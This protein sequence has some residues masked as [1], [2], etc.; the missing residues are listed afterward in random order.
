MKSVLQ[1]RLESRRQGTKDAR[2]V[3]AGEP[4]AADSGEWVGLLGINAGD[5][6][7]LLT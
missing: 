5:D 7:E 6:N 4:V 2:R 3:N 1:R